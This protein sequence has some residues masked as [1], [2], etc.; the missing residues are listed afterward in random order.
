MM[1]RSRARVVRRD[2]QAAGSG[3]DQSAQ[4]GR[5]GGDAGHGMGHRL[6]QRHAGVGRDRG[7]TVDVQDGPVFGTHRREFGHRDPLADPQ[8]LGASAQ[9]DVG[10]PLP[11]DHELGV[12]A[13]VEHPAGRLQE[14]HEP[15]HLVERTAGA[16]HRHPTH[17]R[18]A[19]SVPRARRS[20]A[21]SRRPEIPAGPARSPAGPPGPGGSPTPDDTTSGSAAILAPT[22]GS[23]P[24]SGCMAARPI[25]KGSEPTRS[26]R[27]GSHAPGPAVAQP[28]STRASAPPIPS[29]ND[30]PAPASRNSAG[31]RPGRFPGRGTR[32]AGG[33]RAVPGDRAT[34]PGAI[35]RRTGSSGRP[36]S[37]SSARRLP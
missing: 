28:R 37:G 30:C 16:D 11:G 1:A 22:S 10:R 13:G 12:A 32:P 25:P 33:S 15:R 9:I 27:R 26:S 18:P 24:P 14:H 19:R 2:D 17:Q 29:S 36:G 5:G 20:P 35:A 4:T 34:G 7:L 31:R 23:R 21:R 6:K 8:A 3:L